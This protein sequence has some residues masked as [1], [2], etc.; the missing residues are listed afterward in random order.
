MV[1]SGKIKSTAQIKAMLTMKPKI[2]NVIILSGRV[3]ISNSGFTKE[4]IIP[5]TMPK[6]TITCHS[7]VKGTPKKLE[8]GDTF[9]TIPGINQTAIPRPKMPAMMRETIF[10][11]DS[12]SIS[13]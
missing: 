6:S 5:I 1:I 13:N 4:L 8:S 7:V 11:I 10:L 12:A 9:R 2:P 3:I